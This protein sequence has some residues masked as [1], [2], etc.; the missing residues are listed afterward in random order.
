MPELAE[1]K[2][3][4][5]YINESSRGLKFTSIKKNP[6]HKGV[7]VESPFEKFTINA[8]SRGKE[9]VI[10]L[11][12]Y[13]TGSTVPL[14]MT[15]GMAGHFRHTN[16]GQ[17]NKHA[18]LKFYST[19]GTT[20]SFVD[21]RRF[22]KWKL[23]FEWSDNRSPDPTVE[24]DLFVENIMN[25]LHRKAFDK[26][27]CEVLMNQKYFN[28]IGNYLRAEIIF[29]I[30]DLDP[31][32]PARDAIK[33]F[34]DLLKYCKALPLYAFALGGGKIKDWKNPF[35]ENASKS[36]FFLCYSQKVMSN[37][38]DGSGRRFWYDPKW[39]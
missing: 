37:K 28:G 13:E 15:M 25:N 14:R 39:D 33:D 38:I 11:K 16:T 19:D 27:I 2:L 32:M 12:D 21:V 18:H 4:A 6:V 3:T 23:G 35:D 20:L 10:Y 1:L 29:R 31:F 30:G 36:N 24:Y 5:Q 7:D 34:P 22:G 8:E 17:E 9:L 26:P